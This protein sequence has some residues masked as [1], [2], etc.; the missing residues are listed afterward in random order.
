MEGE[1]VGLTLLVF[2]PAAIGILLFGGAIWMLSPRKGKDRSTLVTVL[3][4]LMLIGSLGIGAC[5]GLMF[6]GA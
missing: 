6:V 5:Y 3:A 4:V 1:Y 2:G